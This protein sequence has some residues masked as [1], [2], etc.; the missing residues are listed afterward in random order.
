M[1]SYGM[2]QFSVFGILGHIQVLGAAV[3]RI[4]PTFKYYVILTS[5]V[6]V[7]CFVFFFR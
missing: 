2:R 6:K 7:L 3:C 4:T 5:P 1:C